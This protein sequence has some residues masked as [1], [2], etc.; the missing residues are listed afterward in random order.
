MNKRFLSS[1]A[2]TLL[3]FGAI[4]SNKAQARDPHILPPPPL[5]SRS[6]T[7]LP[8]SVV[9]SRPVTQIVIQE[10]EPTVTEIKVRNKTVTIIDNSV[11]TVKTTVISIPVIISPGPA[12]PPPPPPH[13]LPHLT[14]PISPAPR[15][16]PRGRVR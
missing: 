10:R 14:P 4:I 15:L 8:S 6:V 16:I 9:T 1:A 3:T 13:R 5:H 7:V 12:L 11:Q 2:A